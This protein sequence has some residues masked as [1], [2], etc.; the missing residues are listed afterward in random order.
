M[1]NDLENL[2]WTTNLIKIK[3]NSMGFTSHSHH[4]IIVSM[5]LSYLYRIISSKVWKEL[6]T[7]EKETGAQ[8][9]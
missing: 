8:W 2:L 3:L 7:F 9:L 5:P 6:I 4:L 1:Y